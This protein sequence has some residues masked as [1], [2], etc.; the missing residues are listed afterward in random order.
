MKL[1][2]PY[3]LEENYDKPIQHI[4]K[5]RPYF[6]YKGRSSQSYAFSSSHVWMWELDHKESWVPKNWCFWTVALKKTLESPLDFK[7]IKP[8]NP[9]GYKPWKVIERILKLKLQY[10]GYLMR[11]TDSTE[12]YP[13]ARESWMQEEKESREDEM[14]EWHH[15]LN[16]HQFEWVLRV[17][18]GQGS[19]VCCSP[20]GCKELDMTEQLYWTVELVIFT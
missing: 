20:W 12:K 2:D 1:K 4:K 3:S 10:F 15:R 19:L 6:A 14:V 18:D 17:A 11:R 9:K 8:V 5:Q 7:E 16:G 13:D